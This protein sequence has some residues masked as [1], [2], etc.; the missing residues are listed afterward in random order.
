MKQVS[1]FHISSDD[2]VSKR[3]R[4]FLRRSDTGS[5]DRYQNGLAIEGP[6]VS[7][8]QFQPIYTQRRHGNVCR[9]SI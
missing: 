6:D 8:V 2:N 3:R 1:R 9:R 7:I 5:F 4:W